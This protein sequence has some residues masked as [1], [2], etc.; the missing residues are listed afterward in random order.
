MC[1]RDKESVCVCVCVHTCVVGAIPNSLIVSI[2][3]L[4]YLYLYVKCFR[5]KSKSEEFLEGRPLYC[6]VNQ[7]AVHVSNVKC[8]WDQDLCNDKDSPTLAPPPSKVVDSRGKEAGKFEL[9]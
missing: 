8:C 1:V 7:Q 4:V 3:W 5:C 2:I 9:C 6:E